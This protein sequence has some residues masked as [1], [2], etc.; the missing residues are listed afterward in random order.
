MK[1]YITY[2]LIFICIIII[3]PKVFADDEELEEDI[4]DTAWIYEQIEAASSN[5][6]NE[7]IINSRAAVV[8]DRTSGEVI[9]GKE[10][11]TQRKMASTTKIMTSIIVIEKIENL[12]QTV[13]ISSKAAGIGGSRLGLHTGDKITVNDLLYGLMLESGNDCAIALGEYVGNTVEN[14]VEI[15]NEKA[16]QLG[17]SNTHFV[18]VNGLDADEHYTTAE[19]LAK[20][21]DYALKNEKFKNIVGTKNYTV[22]IN[23][24]GKAIDNTNELLGY[25]D[26]VY[27]V[28][29]GFTNG[30]NRC[31][32]TS[33][34]RGNMDIIS[35]VLGADTKK[36][37]TKD[38]IEIIEYVYANY[39]IIDV[40]QDI[41]KAFQEWKNQNK[42]ETIKGEM[43]Y[44]DIELSECK[45]KIIPI[46]SENIKDIEIKIDSI[47]IVEAP[48]NKGEKI[49]KLVLNVNEETRIS[50]DIMIAKD[51]K[52][53]DEK[54]YFIEMLSNIKEYWSQIGST[55]GA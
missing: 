52:K 7:P 37:R 25:L 38:S 4:N 22:T 40:T 41:E 1:K 54:R 27:G 14:F 50:I 55:F 18:T 44:V 32:V 36:D 9:W 43:K 29:T 26:G 5:V 53:K 17:L 48:I 3:T 42:I 45:S 15:M 47:K 12:S 6:T 21:T 24:Y 49:G 13:T 19:E 8:Y 2:I 51:I 11:K 28:K 30:A 23:G 10:E 46:K 20:L 33:I 35:V 16:K 39:K 31:L 34:K